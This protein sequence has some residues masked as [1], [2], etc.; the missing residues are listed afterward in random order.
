MYEVPYDKKSIEQDKYEF[1]IGAKTYKVR[2]AKHL[3]GNEAMAVADR[4]DLEAMYDLFGERGT[5]I[6]DIVREIPVSMFNDLL[7]DWAK[8]DGIS[9]GEFLAS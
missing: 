8:S 6:G 3:S 1:K 5:P 7:E 2:R 9:L 4:Q